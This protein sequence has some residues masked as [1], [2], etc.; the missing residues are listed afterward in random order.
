MGV[1]ISHMHPYGPTRLNAPFDKSIGSTLNAFHDLRTHDVGVCILA[2]NESLFLTMLKNL[3]QDQQHDF[4]LKHTVPLSSVENIVLSPV[5]REIQ[6]NTNCAFSPSIKLLEQCVKFRLIISTTTRRVNLLY[7]FQRS[8][9]D[10]V[11]SKT[12]NS[13][14]SFV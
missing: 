12:N 13:S 3:Q 14:I 6:H 11:W 9:R 4:R 5:S 2:C 10:F 1:T 7:R 8:E